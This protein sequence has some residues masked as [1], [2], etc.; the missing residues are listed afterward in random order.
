MG[1]E[2]DIRTVTATTCADQVVTVQDT[3]QLEGEQ[4]QLAVEALMVK[5]AAMVTT[6][7]WLCFG[8]TLLAF[9]LSAR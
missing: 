1:E 2:V 4:Q 9:P 7:P 8:Y 6:V 5:M 3:E